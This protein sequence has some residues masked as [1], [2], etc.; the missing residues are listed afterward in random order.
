M[1]RLKER[2]RPVP[3]A[4]GQRLPVCGQE[5]T[6]IHTGGRG[7]VRIEG[8]RLLVPGE[9]AFMARRVRDWVK[10]LAREE[11]TRLAQAKAVQL[12]VRIKRISVRDTVSRWGSCSSDGALSFS[13]RLAFAPYPVMDYVVCH[14]V[15]HIKEHNHGPAFWKR[16]A[17]LCP[18]HKEARAWLR[19]H[20]A[21]LYAYG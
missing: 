8:D 5:L 1:E 14:E 9:E 11:I 4:C 12:G 2:V 17:E 19:K 3:F 20:G 10:S 13:W 6:L 7:L 15:A 18:G 16:V 21:T